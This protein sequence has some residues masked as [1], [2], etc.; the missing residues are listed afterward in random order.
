MSWRRMTDIA[1]LGADTILTRLYTVNFKITQHL[2]MNSPLC[3]DVFCDAKA[4]LTGTVHYLWAYMFGSFCM[5]TS[6]QS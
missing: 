6:S 5:K 2:T 1:A 4:S 3:P